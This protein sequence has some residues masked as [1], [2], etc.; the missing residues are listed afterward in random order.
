MSLYLLVFVFGAIAIYE[1]NAVIIAYQKLSDQFRPYVS[2]LIKDFG[3]TKKR[4]EILV[5]VQDPTFFEHSGIEWPSPLT[6]TT[7]TQSI[8]KKNFFSRNSRKALIK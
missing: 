4:Q 7:I 1:A 8:V 5:K 2:V 6:T 3:L